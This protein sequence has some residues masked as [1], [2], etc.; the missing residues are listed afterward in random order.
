MDQHPFVYFI[1]S[2]TFYQSGPILHAQ[3]L[4]SCGNHVIV[5]G[6][7]SGSKSSQY[8]D[9]KISELIIVLWAIRIIKISKLLLTGCN[10]CVGTIPKVDKILNQMQRKGFG[11]CL[12]V[13]ENL[14]SNANSLYLII[15]LVYFS[16]FE[17]LLSNILGQKIEMNHSC[18]PRNNSIHCA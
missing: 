17:L 6:K 10:F 1:F 13:R 15:D 4:I 18:G 14:D 11:I 5:I 7:Y 16:P 8:Y 2:L 9:C 12:E 3:T